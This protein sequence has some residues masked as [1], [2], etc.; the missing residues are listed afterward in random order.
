MSATNRII[1]AAQF[2]DRIVRY[3]TVE[4]LLTTAQIRTLY[5]LPVTILAAQG[6][7]TISIPWS[8]L[9]VLKAGAVAFDASLANVGLTAG[10]SIEWGSAVSLGDGSASVAKLADDIDA[11]T[12]DLI[13]G[14]G[15]NAPLVVSN[16]VDVGDGDTQ[17][18]AV[19]VS[20]YVVNLTGWIT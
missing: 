9:F 1:A 6:A 12:V 7:L 11:T 16:N 14:G 8:C 17:T 4:A 2:A 18:L 5:S 10:T 15:V 20:Y 3:G 13:D 19:L